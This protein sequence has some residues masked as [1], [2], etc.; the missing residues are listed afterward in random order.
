MVINPSCSTH[1]VQSKLNMQYQTLKK[2][3]EKYLFEKTSIC[4]QEKKKRKR[5]RND[6]T[7]MVPVSHPQGR[8]QLLC[9]IFHMTVVAGVGYDVNL[10]SQ[11]IT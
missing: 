2:V 6:K 8:M 9:G 10:P 11:T 5:R 7:E 4:R 1:T 3:K